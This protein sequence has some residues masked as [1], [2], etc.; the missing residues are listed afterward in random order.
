MTASMAMLDRDNEIL[1]LKKE[2]SD[3]EAN[4]AVYENQETIFDVFKINLVS[5]SFAKA[6]FLY[7]FS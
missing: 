4:L 5:N 1:A 6:Y 3:L 7:N 2:K